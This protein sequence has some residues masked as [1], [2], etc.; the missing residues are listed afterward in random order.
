MSDIY[1]EMQ[2]V[3]QDV[4]SEFSQ[5]V[6]EYVSL[7]SGDG[8]VDNPGPPVE[9]VTTLKGATAR[10]VSSKYVDGTIIFTT[11]IQVNMS[12]QTGIAPQIDDFINIDG[13]R[14]KIIKPM[15]V[16]AS[17]T[18]VAHILIVRR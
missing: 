9:T 3:T 7:T 12:V 14:H 2:K 16:P 1:Q 5:G 8:P 6:V 4:M 15:T 17:G 10:N 13:V 18:P 11:D